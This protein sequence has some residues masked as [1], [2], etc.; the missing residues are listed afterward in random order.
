LLGEATLETEVRIDRALGKHRISHDGC[1]LSPSQ[2]A[3]QLDARTLRELSG[4]V[5]RYILSLSSRHLWVISRSQ[6]RP[7]S[8]FL[9]QEIGGWGDQT[10]RWCT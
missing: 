2:P 5:V 9:H 6:T 10:L 7:G 4:V 3:V 1:A 8:R